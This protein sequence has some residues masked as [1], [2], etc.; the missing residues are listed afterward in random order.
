MNRVVHFEIHTGRPEE[1]AAFYREVFGW[2]IAEWIIPGVVL[3]EE[4]R[5]WAVTTGSEKEPGINGGIVKRPRPAP[6][7]DKGVSAFVCTIQVESVDA[8]LNKVVEAGGQIATP[9]MPIPGVGWLAY[10]KD[11]EGNLFGLM[12]VDADSV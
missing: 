6:D 8:Y 1:T 9:K 3:P 11:P 5:Y 10:A 4:H 7:E 12:Q 2:T